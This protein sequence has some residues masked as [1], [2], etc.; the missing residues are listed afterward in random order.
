M[1]IGDFVQHKQA[2]GKDDKEVESIPAQI[3]GGEKDKWKIVYL[4]PKKTAPTSTVTDKQLAGEGM[5][6]RTSNDFS[7]SLGELAGNA[8]MY[9]VIQAVR[10]GPTFGNRFMSFVGSDVAY[11]LLLRG[12]IDDFIPFMRPDSFA[13]KLGVRSS[14]F[15]DAMKTIPVVIIQQIVCKVMYRSGLT[16][17]IFKNLLDAFGA[18][19]TSNI[20]TRNARTYFEEDETKLLYRY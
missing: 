19:V 2:K 6:G 8:L 3:V 13:N 14:D 16:Q 9:G 18:Y 12:M 5:F 4:D 20:V 15:K 11:E 7:G 17:H 1:R 10:S